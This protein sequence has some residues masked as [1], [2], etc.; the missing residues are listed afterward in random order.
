MPS[1]YAA[2]LRLLYTIAAARLGCST[3]FMECSW[4]MSNTVHIAL[5]LTA[6]PYEFL[7]GIRGYIVWNDLLLNVKD[8]ISS[9][10]LAR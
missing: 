5:Y 4:P 8:V 7:L 9:T 6:I 3:K 10:D 1:I 2:A